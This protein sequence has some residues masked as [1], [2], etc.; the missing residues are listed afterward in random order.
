MNPCDM[1][2]NIIIG[3]MSDYKCSM[4][5]AM[6]WDIETFGINLRSTSREYIERELNHYFLS[7]GMCEEHRDSWLTLYM[8][9]VDYG[10]K[11]RNVS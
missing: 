5:T 4:K 2:S 10:L 1:Y 8:S 3:M 7:Y 11:P 6:T 9:N